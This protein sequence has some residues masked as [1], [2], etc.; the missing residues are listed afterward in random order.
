MME[1]KAMIERLNQLY[2]QS[3][4]RELTREEL[5]ERDRLRRIYLD[6][7]RNQVQNSL[8][9]MNGSGQAGAEPDRHQCDGNC[10]CGRD[11]RH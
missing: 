9:G 6:G 5:V 2:H 10:R 8:E 7:I 4:E 3:R 11:C 1:F